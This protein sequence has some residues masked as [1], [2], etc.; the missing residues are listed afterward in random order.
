MG[1]VNGGVLF[2]AG[3]AVGVGAVL[4]G[5]T[6]WRATRPLAKS[7]LRAGIEGY[8]TASLTAARVGEE[9]EDLVAEVVMEMNEAAPAAPAAAEGTS[10][11]A[12]PAP[13]HVA[14]ADR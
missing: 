7:A 1:R 14:P 6:I 2:G 13:A 5:P 8:A 4:F 3:I 10:A 9:L 11:D 12:A